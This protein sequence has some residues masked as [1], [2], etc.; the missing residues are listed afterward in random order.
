[1][2]LASLRDLFALTVLE[3]VS[4]RVP[5]SVV[6]ELLEGIVLC[7]C[8]RSRA[9]ENEKQAG[10]GVSRVGVDEKRELADEKA[11]PTGRKAGRSV[12]T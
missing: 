4:L 1:M 8:F 2:V 7:A 10:G 9:L 6:L 11:G 12:V 3:E 5:R